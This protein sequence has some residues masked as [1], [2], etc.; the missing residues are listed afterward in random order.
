MSVLVIGMKFGKDDQNTHLDAKA[1]NETIA[2]EIQKAKEVGYDFTFYSIDPASS[3]TISEIRDLVQS[4]KFDCVSIGFAV[5]G[6]PEATTL[7][8]DVLNVC[9]QEIKPL[10]KF[11]FAL[12]PNMVVER[13]QR[14]L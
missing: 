2:K 4:K 5:R 12:R 11:V 9:A 6:V 14:V 3:Y 13:V 7:F 8:E 10:P 1:V